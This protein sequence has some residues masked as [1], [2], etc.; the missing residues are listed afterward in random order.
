MVHPK[1]M[2]IGAMFVLLILAVVLLP[3]IVRYIGKN[4]RYY[5]ISGFQNPESDVMYTVPSVVAS[6]QP[7]HYVPDIYTNYSC[8]SPPNSGYMP[9]KEGQ[10]CNGTLGECIDISPKKTNKVEGYYS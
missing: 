3:M 1:A 9:C 2:G 7:P 5:S 10:F 8:N 6:S 4:D